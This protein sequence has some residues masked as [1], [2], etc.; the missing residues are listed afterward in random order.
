MDKMT[1]LET[2][3][4]GLSQQGDN[5]LQNII[6]RF[7][8]D[9]KKK[10]ILLQLKA[11]GQLA[12]IVLHKKFSLVALNDIL[13]KLEPV[14]EFYEDLGGL[15]GYFDTLIDL[16][17]PKSQQVDSRAYHA[18]NFIDISELT[19]DVLQTVDDGISS[20]PF[21]A[22]MF[23]LG[24]AADR[25][26]LK[27]AISNQQLPAAK[28]QFAGKSLLARLIEDI[29]AREYLYFLQTGKQIVTPIAIMTS[30]EKNNHGHIVQMLEESNF[31]GRPA[32]SFKLFIQPL[33]PVINETGDFLLT[34]DCELV[35]KPGGHGVI[36]KLANQKNVFSWLKTLGKTK[37]LIRQ[38]N[39]PVA[40][41]D[42]GILSFLGIGFKEDKK[43]GFASCPR[44]VKAAE[45][46]NVLVQ[47]ETNEG[48]KMVLTNIEYCDFAKFGIED[49]PRNIGEQ[50]SRFSSNT[51][52]LFADI[53]AI[54]QA[55]KEKPYPGLLFNL[56]PGQYIDKQGQNHVVCMGR[57]EST[58]QNIADVFE[59]SCNDCLIPKDTFI[60]Y[61][62]RH[63]TISTTKKAYEAGAC[64]LE[65]PQSCFYDLM[66]S[67]R[68]L[69][70]E[71]C[72]F[73]LPERKTLQE[74]LQTFPEIIFL[75]HPCLGPVF[76]SIGKKIQR[77][78]LAEKSFLRL[79]IG[80]VAIS[81]LNLDG[82]LDV[83][84]RSVIGADEELGHLIFSTKVGNVELRNV[85]VQNSGLDV[86]QSQPFWRGD[87]HFKE[88]LHVEL[89]GNSRFIAENV[90]FYGNMK[91]IVE[92]GYCCHVYEK[93]GEIITHNFPI[94]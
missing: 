38:I 8:S 12:K 88:K 20:V 43:F 91:F 48:R 55:V 15:K 1:D 58:M 14:D 7:L 61:N 32:E 6:D 41:V 62:K 94:F 67:A 45:G 83:I 74:S 37:L 27:D 81:D 76:P 70:F 3:I 51:N 72:N 30:L 63:K 79:E 23:A 66:T 69:L 31:F 78:S 82:A 64:E 26:L 46:V 22:E 28:L 18:P 53:E 50:Y 80:S 39:N 25:L 92:D 87:Y 34:Q 49:K 19:K 84:A 71:N 10:S 33:V 54:V 86:D 73:T 29:Q 24:G 5:Q 52:L 2:E 77:G 65:T 9:E 90:T 60:T 56:K 59:E 93:N 17:H 16:L 68:E 36:W 47:A 57:L 89:L 75:Y 21:M 44:L 85:K 4:L 35:L 13:E 40:G 11:T 42:Y